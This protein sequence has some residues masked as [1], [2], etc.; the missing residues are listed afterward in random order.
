MANGFYKLDTILIQQN[1]YNS[2]PFTHPHVVN[3]LYDLLSIL[4]TDQ[5][6]PFNG[7]FWNECVLILLFT[8][9]LSPDTQ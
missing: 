5:T 6:V 9:Q 1:K 7:K 4:D 8:V 2:S 3:I